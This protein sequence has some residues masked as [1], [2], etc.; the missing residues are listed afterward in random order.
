MLWAIAW[1][2][3]QRIEALLCKAGP[4]EHVAADDSRL[5]TMDPI[6]QERYLSPEDN[7]IPGQ[8]IDHY[9]FRGLKAM[10][11]ASLDIGKLLGAEETLGE[12]AFKLYSEMSL[13]GIQNQ[14]FFYEKKSE[15][16][17]VMFGINIPT[18]KIL[19]VLAFELHCLYCIGMP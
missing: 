13:L 19:D 2:R 11:R 3:L 17:P 14:P 8:Y 7:G 4:F 10:A 6:R 15:R 1:Q 12:N 18:F 9:T 16:M 5:G